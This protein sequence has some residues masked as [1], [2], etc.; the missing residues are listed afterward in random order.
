MMARRG[1]WLNRTAL[2]SGLLLGLSGAP[3]GAQ[4][5]ERAPLSGPDVQNNRAPE[6]E[7][8]FAKG[9]QRRGAMAAERVPM[10]AYLMSLSKLRGE[11]V[12]PEIRLSDEQEDKISQIQAEFMAAT[13]QFAAAAREGQRRRGRDGRAPDAMQEPMNDRPQGRPAPEARRPD[14]ARVEELRRNAPRPEDYQVKIWAVLSEPQREVVTKEL[15]Q[16]KEELRQRREQQY[17]ER[18][19]AQ[20]N[21]AAPGAGQAPGQPP[22]Q[23]PAAERVRRIMEKLQQLPPEEREQL[24]RRIEEELDRRTGGGQIRR[25]AREAGPKPPPSMDDVPVPAPRR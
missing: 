19:A 11:D 9:R 22:V 21:P 17:M 5:G 4:Q 16:V 20:R 1:T 7:D 15:E 25:P 12:S 23:R 8:Q 24:L 10:R 18:Q 13:R 2:V 14:P 6:M 3:A